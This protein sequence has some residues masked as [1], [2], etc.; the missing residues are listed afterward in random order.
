M[1]NASTT[2]EYRGRRYDVTD[3][4][5]INGTTEGFASVVN[6]RGH[7]NLLVVVVDGQGRIVRA[8]TKHEPWAD[9]TYV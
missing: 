2:I 7:S 4:N 1:S 8:A 3:L 9:V 5:V 6:S